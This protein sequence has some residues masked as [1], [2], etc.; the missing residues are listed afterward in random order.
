MGEFFLKKKSFKVSLLLLLLSIVSGVFLLRLENYTSEKI[1]RFFYYTDKFK[2]IKLPKK[3]M[4]AEENKTIIDIF[5]NAAKEHK[6]F[7]LFKVVDESYVIENDFNFKFLPKE[8]IT[9]YTPNIKNTN[10]H[11]LPLSESVLSIEPIDNLTAKNE[12]EWHFFI[13]TQ[14]NKIYKEIINKINKDYNQAFST[15]YTVADFSDFERMQDFQLGKDTDIYNVTGLVK[16]GFVFLMVILSFWVTAFRRRINILHLNGYTVLTIVHNLVGRGYTI[17][18]CLIPFL[19]NLLFKG[20]TQSWSWVLFIFILLLIIVVYVW[21]LLLVILVVKSN[22]LKS[23]KEEVIRKINGVLPS[24]VKLL[25]LMMLVVTNLHLAIIIEHAVELNTDTNIPK[26]I[27]KDNYHVF[28]PIVV[29]KNNVQ[30]IY[31]NSYSYQESEEIYHFLNSR[32]SL[33]VDTTDYD[34]KENEIFG[35]AIK[36]NPNYLKKFPIVDTDNQPISIEESETSRVLLI[37]IGL[38]KDR[39]LAEIKK[40]F[41]EELPAYETKDTKIIYIQD[42]Q[43]VYS[44][45][46][47]RPWIVDYPIIDVLTINNSTGWEKN[48]F[49]GDMY[50]PLKVKTNDLEM[51]ELELFIEKRQLSDNLIS[52]IPYQ[53][54]EISLIKRLSG[55]FSH[56]VM[57]LILTIFTFSIITVLTTQYVFKC[58]RRKFGLLRLNGYSFFKT[59]DKVFFYLLIELISAIA[60]AFSLSEING[61]FVF[62]IAIAMVL[63]FVIVFFALY[64]GERKN[65]RYDI[66]C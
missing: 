47:K 48:I 23:E 21:L 31:D 63:N 1:D 32:D 33:L 55:S 18:I 27:I 61:A 22:T 64:L 62:N 14:N 39:R 59:Y 3:I 20:M 36:I 28:Y 26:S 10:S 46:P 24:V 52:F 17:F 40:Y 35:R 58:N 29:G 53:N 45:I 44:F 50:P 41:Y 37:P 25:F 38:K 49:N 16:I 15:D 42:N 12:F 51:K 54:V 8:D 6:L 65:N 57:S 11:Q 2:P 5:G 9:L 4:K 34:I 60:I 19:T 56:L 30:F 7:Y 13:K 66:S 43:A